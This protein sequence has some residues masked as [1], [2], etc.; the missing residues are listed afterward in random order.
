[1][2]LQIYLAFFVNLIYASL[3]CKYLQGQRYGV[4]PTLESL[5]GKFVQFLCDHFEPDLIEKFHAQI[6]ENANHFKP[7]SKNAAISLYVQRVL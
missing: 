5:L 2:K 1:M 3:L 7:H 6:L 4:V